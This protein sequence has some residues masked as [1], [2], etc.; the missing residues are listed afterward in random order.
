MKYLYALT[1]LFLI[2]CADTDG[3]VKVSGD[4]GLNLQDNLT[5]CSI[6]QEGGFYFIEK[7][8]LDPITISIDFAIIYPIGEYVTLTQADLLRVS[9]LTQ[10]ELDIIDGIQ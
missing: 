1:F 2:G 6:R 3:T 4:A 5:E 7:D 10:I 9:P 8:G